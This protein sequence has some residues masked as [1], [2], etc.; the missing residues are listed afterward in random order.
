MAKRG[1]KN[2]AKRKRS[3]RPLADLADRHVLYE[4][5]TAVGVDIDPEVLAWGREHNVARLDHDARMRL[6]LI[7][8]DVF[9]VKID[10][11]DITVA[12]NFSYWIF[13]TRDTLRGYFEAVRAGPM[14]TMTTAATMSSS[15]P[16]GTP[17]A[18]RTARR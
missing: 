4:R 2:R 18:S 13:N 5:H 10:P 17:R 9:K 12:F 6:K 3:A 16:I 14:A 11:V 15:K 1:T 8:D 7:E